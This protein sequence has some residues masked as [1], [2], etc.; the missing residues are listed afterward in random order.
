[1]ADGSRRADVT[2]MKPR[3][4]GRPCL[5]H[6]LSLLGHVSTLVMGC[7]HTWN[8]M[9]DRMRISTGIKAWEDVHEM[10]CIREQENT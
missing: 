4:N 1:M 5:A 6:L 2:D 3:L 10:S 7:M 8:D 9:R